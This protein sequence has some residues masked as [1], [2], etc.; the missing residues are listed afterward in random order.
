MVDPFQAGKNQRNR[1]RDIACH[2]FAQRCF[3][4]KLHAP[5][6]LR[7]GNG[8]KILLNIGN[9]TQSQCDCIGDLVGN[10]DAV[11]TGRQLAWIGGKQE[12]QPWRNRDKIFDQ[13]IQLIKH[14]LL[15]QCIPTDPFKN[16]VARTV[17]LHPIFW[18]EKIDRHQIQKRKEDDKF[19][20]KSDISVANSSTGK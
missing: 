5:C 1:D 4:R 7:F 11:D 3:F 16:H 6:L 17:D 10:P 18:C 20:Y 12:N 14:L 9:V 2:S 13:Q 15:G 19:Q 8:P